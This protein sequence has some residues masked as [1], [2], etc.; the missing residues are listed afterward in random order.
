M[1]TSRQREK[2]S[3]YFAAHLIASKNVTGETNSHV[4][5]N[6]TMRVVPIPPISL[7]WLINSNGWPLGRV[8]SCSGYPKT[9]KSAFGYQ[10]A[11][12]YMAYNGIAAL[13]DTENKTHKE[14]MKSIV[15]GSEMFKKY[16]KSRQFQISIVTKAD[17]WRDLLEKWQA[18]RITAFKK[19]ENMP[20]PHFGLI[21]S[22]TSI[23][24]REAQEQLAD[25][26]GAVGEDIAISMRTFSRQLTGWPATIHTVH[27]QNNYSDG[28]QGKARSS[29][30]VSADYFATVD[31]LFK[32]GGRSSYNSAFATMPKFGKT[33]KIITIEVRH[34][35]IGPDGKDQA[36]SVPVL[37]RYVT[38]EET[39]KNTRMMY[40]DWGAADAHFLKQ[41][42]NRLMDV[43]DI[44]CIS[45]RG[46]GDVFWSEKI[47]IK[48]DTPMEASYF[49]LLIQSNKEIMSKIRNTL[50]IPEN[51][52]LEPIEI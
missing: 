16:G 22:L 25:E 9:H 18:E 29:G 44:H 11:G 50:C 41:H 49:G 13:I 38:N 23:N 35:T 14:V 5:T 51:E 6:H 30:A 47:G 8:T 24:Y 15:G 20:I 32:A 52:I 19:G 21:D 4:A 40:F 10:L 17:E 2:I 45:I 42:A 37:E 34:S 1:A 28:L 46:K 31:L 27:R 7:Q 12:W 3:E 43:L 39:G 33:G 26:V 36:I 48:E